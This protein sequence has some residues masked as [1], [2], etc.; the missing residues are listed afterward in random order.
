[1]VH[2]VSVIATDRALICLGG[3]DIRLPARATVHTEGRCDRKGGIEAAVQTIIAAVIS[4][5]EDAVQWLEDSSDS[6]ANVLFEERPLG[7]PEQL[8]AFKL[9]AALSQ[10]SAHRSDANRHDRHRRHPAPGQ[11]GQGCARPCDR[12][13]LGIC[14]STT[15]E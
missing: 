13:A 8:Y 11:E 5:Y 3:S 12:S 6:L 10:L 2:P 7:K 4:T 14:L 9:R 15:P 1:M